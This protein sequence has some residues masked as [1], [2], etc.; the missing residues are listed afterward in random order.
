MK[1]KCLRC[2]NQRE[3]AADVLYGGK[4]GEIIRNNVCTICWAEW[5]DMEMKM[6]NEYRINFSDPNHRSFIG[7]KM[8]EFLNLLNVQ[9]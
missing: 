6:I 8:K 4:I 5:Q 7:Q 3:Q 9:K 2:G 1:V